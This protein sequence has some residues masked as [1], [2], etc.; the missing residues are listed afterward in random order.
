L[1]D[2]RESDGGL[3]VGTMTFG[4][5]MVDVLFHYWL[6]VMAPFVMA[7][8]IPTVIPVAIA[9][10][11]IPIRVTMPPA[12]VVTVPVWISFAL[13]PSVMM[14]MVRL[15]ALMIALV[16]LVPFALFTSV[17]ICPGVAAY[18]QSESDQCYAYDQDLPCHVNLLR[19]G[20]RA[21]PFGLLTRMTRVTA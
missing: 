21:V 12:M 5:M 11:V 18:C 8:T 13:M 9:I 6:K 7:I 17:V 2:Y 15:V 19:I 4:V 3:V 16:I 20:L 1:I 14:S 10:K